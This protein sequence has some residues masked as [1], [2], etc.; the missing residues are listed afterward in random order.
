MKATPEFADMIVEKSC[1]YLTLGIDWSTILY[2]SDI[3]T[4]LSN[5]FYNPRLIKSE[6]M[7]LKR[8]D[9][10]P[11]SCCSEWG[12]IRGKRFLCCHKIQKHFVVLYNTHKV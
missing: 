1:R 2:L 12:S 6:F 5:S 7:F 9:P 11:A 4:L 10:T 8:L 3:D